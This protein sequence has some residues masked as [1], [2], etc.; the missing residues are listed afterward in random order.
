MEG[1]WNGAEFYLCRAKTKTNFVFHQTN[2][3]FQMEFVSFSAPQTTLT[4]NRNVQ[5]IK[6]YM[7]IWTLKLL[8]YHHIWVIWKFVFFFSYYFGLVLREP[9]LGCIS[10]INRMCYYVSTSSGLF[11]VLCV[12]ISWCNINPAELTTKFNKRTEHS[13]RARQ[14]DRWWRVW[15]RKLFQIKEYLICQV[16]LKQS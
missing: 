6:I 15:A 7:I 4:Q 14:T 10:S 11:H 2:F 1:K 5:V 12:C 8:N 3:S 16:L 9:M 13:P